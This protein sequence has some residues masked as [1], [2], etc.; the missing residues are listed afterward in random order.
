MERLA[1][2]DCSNAGRQ[3]DVAVSHSKLAAVFEKLSNFAQAL[4]ELHAARA[5]IAELAAAAPADAQWQRDLAWLDQRIAG[6]E[7]QTPQ[8]AKN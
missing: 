4:I 2:L 3:R 8:S 7:A 6:I 5:I 1:A